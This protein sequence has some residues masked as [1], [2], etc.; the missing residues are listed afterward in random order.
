MRALLR[1]AGMNKREGDLNEH[2]RT[3][4]NEVIEELNEI[5][6]LQHSC[7]K[8]KEVALWMQL[9]EKMMSHATSYTNLIL[10]AGYAGFFGFW[11]T[12]VTRLPQWVYAI[13]GLLALVSLLIFVSWE[14]TKMIWSYRYLNKNNETIIKI[15]RG[16]K[17][18]Q[19]LEAAM[20]LHS[21][22]VHR[23]WKWFLIPTVVTGISAALLLLGTFSYQFWRSIC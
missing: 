10:V 5:K 8:D 17:P 23:M 20:N 21:I 2:F 22:K 16:D 7:E 9:N 6:K 4:M 18:L 14:I 13:S 3:K 11:S 15:K 1:C 19:M 12:I